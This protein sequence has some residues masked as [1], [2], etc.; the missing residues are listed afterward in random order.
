MA[1]NAWDVGGPPDRDWARIALTRAASSPPAK[2][3][4]AALLHLHLDPVGGISGDMFVASLL[5]A[6]PQLWPDVEDQLGRLDIDPPVSVRIFAHNDGCYAGQRFSVDGENPQDHA[7]GPACGHAHHHHGHHHDHGHHDHVTY[8]SIRDLLKRSRLDPAIARVAGAIFGLLADAESRVHGL[9]V[10]N[11]TFH[12]VGSRDSLADI[13]AAATLIVRL[14]VAST[15]VSS[16]PMGRGQIVTAHGPMPLPAPA[17]S[18]LL[19][20]YEFHDDGRPGERVTPTGAAILCYLNPVASPER[21]P[22]RLQASGFGF[23]TRSFDGISNVLR[24]LLMTRG[25]DGQDLDTP[26]KHDQVAEIAFEVDDQ[27]PEDLAAGLDRVRNAEGVIDLIQLHVTG[28][29]GR[30]ASGIRILAAPSALDSVIAACL[31]ETS[32]LGLRHRIV[33][34][35]VLRRRLVQVDCGDTQVGVKLAERPDGELT[36]KADQDDISAGEGAAGRS[37]MRRNAERAAIRQDRS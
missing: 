29:K 5:A 28:K 30:L 18:L 37:H 25:G 9:P 4:D 27:T 20:G 34:R 17:V 14:G 22:L 6:R 35:T 33:D 8:A 23:G 15:S 7:H 24:A 36:A 10:D 32:T 26:L 1:L 16:L 19:Q 13:V 21:S 12:E 2:L 11:V 31:R 3:E